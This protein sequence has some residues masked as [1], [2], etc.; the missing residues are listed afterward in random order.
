M[1]TTHERPTSRRFRPVPPQRHGPV[2]SPVAHGLAAGLALVTIAATIP[3]VA[4][5]GLLI[6]PPA[7]NGSARG[8]AL[9]MLLVGVPLMIASQYATRRGRTVAVPVW[10]GTV[11][12]LLYNAFMLLFA[13]PFNQLFLLYVAMF[14]LGLWSLVSILRAVDVA[15]WARRIRPGTPQRAIAVFCWIVVALNVAAWLRGIIPGLSDPDRAAFL[16]GTGLTTLPTYVQDLAIWLPL[17][18]VA[19]VWLWRGVAWGYLVISAILVQWTVESITIAVD[20]HLGSMADPTSTVTSA[21]MSPVF[22]AVALVTAAV[23]FA[24]LRRM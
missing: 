17:T 6:G 18:V 24:M 16:E 9:V 10:L 8:T 14:S 20:Q 3:T 11:A 22:A 4:V 23:A 7:M 21:A 13:T 12:Y 15:A 5:P 1:S 19:G 2:G